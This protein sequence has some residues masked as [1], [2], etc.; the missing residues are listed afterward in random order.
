MYTPLCRV[1]GHVCSQSAFSTVTF[2][3]LLPAVEPFLLFVHGP[4]CKG[5]FLS[6]VMCL[7]VCK[8][9]CN[10]VWWWGQAV[11]IRCLQA[12]HSKCL[13]WLRR[14]GA[15]GA[16]ERILKMLFGYAFYWTW[17]HTATTQGRKCCT[18]L[19]NVFQRFRD[20]FKTQTTNKTKQQIHGYF[21]VYF[22]WYFTLCFWC[23]L[24]PFLSTSLQKLFFIF[25][26]ISELLDRFS[27]CCL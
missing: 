14:R 23:N 15:V 12:I 16:W 24:C 22:V 9:G 27:I 25:S 1:A 2:L 3:A 10:I 11:L 6:H 26:M 21:E 13:C 17:T 19:K 7:F 4:Y 8:Y 20:R 18:S 5:L